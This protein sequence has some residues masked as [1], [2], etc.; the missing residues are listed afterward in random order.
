MA[1][2]NSKRGAQYSLYFFNCA[3][4]ALQAAKAAGQ[5]PPSGKMFGAI[6]LP[7][8]VYKGILDEEMG[9]NSNAQ[10]TPLGTAA[11]GQPERQTKRRH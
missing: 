2:V 9:G 8:A 10:T 11:N 1:Y 3:T 4:F 5:S 6:C 7:N